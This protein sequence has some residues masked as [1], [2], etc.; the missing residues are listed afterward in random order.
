MEGW[1]AARRL[2]DVYDGTVA[3]A[4]RIPGTRAAAPLG[5]GEIEHRARSVQWLVLEETNVRPFKV[6]V[7]PVRVCAL[8]THTA[9]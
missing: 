4:P 9:K 6:T 5:L 8:H 3:R 2:S 7:L 1:G